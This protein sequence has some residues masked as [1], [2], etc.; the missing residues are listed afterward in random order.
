MTD[1]IVSSH[2]ILGG[3][4]IRIYKPES[5]RIISFFT[6]FYL[7]ALHILAKLVIVG[8]VCFLYIQK[9]IVYANLSYF[10]RQ[11]PTTV[12]Y[13]QIYWP[14]T[15]LLDCALPLIN[16]KHFNNVTITSH[17]FH[18]SHYA[19]FPSCKLVWLLWVPGHSTHFMVHLD[20]FIPFYFLSYPYQPSWW[21]I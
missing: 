5:H 14:N 3:T 16:M 6:H 8:G 10:L 13:W 19:S 11:W 1:I 2:E 12:F 7:V 20:A 21:Q 15:I 4:C 17:K 9:C 18:E